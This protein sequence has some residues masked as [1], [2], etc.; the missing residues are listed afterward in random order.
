MVGESADTN[1]TDIDGQAHRWL[2]FG[3]S[4]SG[5]PAADPAAAKA[6]AD[7]EAAGRRA[8]LDALRGPDAKLVLVFCTGGHDP[9]A[10][11]R[12]VAAVAGA[13][14]LV[15]CSTEAVMTAGGAGG[16]GASNGAA[17]AGVVEGAGVAVVALGGAGFSVTVAA[18]PISGDRQRHGGAEVGLA[19]LTGADDRPNRVLLLLTDGMTPDQEV[20]LSGV[21][22][23]VGASL[24][25]IGGSVG[26]AAGGGRTFLLRDGDILNDAVV[27][28]LIGSD[29]PVGIGLRHGWRRVGDPLVVTHSSNGTVKALNDRPALPT[30]LD[31]LG[32][33]PEAY[34]DPA[35]FH[36]FSRTR[37]IGVSRR[38]GESLRDVSSFD[39]FDEGWLHSSGEI[40][41]GGL[42]CPMEG[43]RASVLAA[44]DAAAHEATGALGDTRALG[45]LAFGCVSR[46]AI[47]GADGTRAEVARLAGAATPLAGIY[48]WGEIG[49]TEGVNAYHNLTMACLAL[50]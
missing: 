47:L 18:A 19:C 39:Y 22:S 35:A 23:V 11:A 1:P 14:P 13:V 41:E 37:P 26:A 7:A 6:G 44:A 5:H 48:T 45:L 30:Y 49:R 9:A 34:R 36:Q 17:G 4:C 43:D 12:G 16:A 24:P 31:R 27:G 21:Y 8:A 10:V 38:A 32:A 50:G 46:R 25:L 40:P 15:G 33:P 2:G 29:G 20:I 3:W 42:V 28:V